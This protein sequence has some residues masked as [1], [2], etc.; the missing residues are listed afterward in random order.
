PFGQ[1]QFHRTGLFMLDGLSKASIIFLAILAIVF[2]GLSIYHFFTSPKLTPTGFYY[3]SIEDI[4]YASETIAV[5]TVVEIINPNEKHDSSYSNYHVSL[6][7]SS[8]LKGAP[9][10]ENDGQTPYI[11]VIQNK[12]DLNN[13]KINGLKKGKNI[14]YFA[15]VLL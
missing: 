5:G 4:Y 14:Y 6:R 12:T 9:S 11:N 13:Q 2:C 8:L 10:S 1:Q 3:S 15:E 7:E